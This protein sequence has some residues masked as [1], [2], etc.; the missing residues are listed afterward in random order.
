MAHD[1]TTESVGAIFG[2]ETSYAIGTRK[3]AEAVVV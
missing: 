3:V 2:I 1:G